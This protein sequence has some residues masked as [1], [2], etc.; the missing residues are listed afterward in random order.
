MWSNLRGRNDRTMTKLIT[1]PKNLYVFLATPGVEVMNL[2]FATDYVF[3]I[4]WKYGA[5][6]DVPN[7]RHTNE[8]IGV[9]VT[10]WARIYLPRPAARERDVL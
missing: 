3:Y 1:E 9:Y 4:S 6:E 10:A 2:A 5:E 7:L 8:V